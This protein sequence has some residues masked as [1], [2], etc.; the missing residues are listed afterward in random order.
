MAELRSDREQ[1]QPR[2]QRETSSRG[3]QSSV[4]ART[5]RSEIRKRSPLDYGTTPFELM[6]RFTDEMNNVF[7]GLLP[8]SRGFGGLG[9]T[10]EELWSPQ[11]EILERDGKLVVRADL[12]G[13]KKDDVR[14][15]FRDNTLIIEGERREEHKEDREGYFLT[16]RTYGNF[17]RAIPLPEGTSGENI[18]ASFSDGVLEVTM[19]APKPQESRGRTIQIEE[20]KSKR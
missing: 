12:P 18:H 20:S 17:Y 8:F 2:S 19:D 9:R 15:E 16:E 4:P 1:Q 10:A 5:Q 14:V 13:L 7:G 3:Q 6:R 11:V